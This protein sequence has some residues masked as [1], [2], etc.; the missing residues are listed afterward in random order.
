MARVRGLV[1]DAKG[2]LDESFVGH[3][4]PHIVAAHA[5]L[6]G[7][8][9]ERFRIRAGSKVVLADRVVLDF[10]T[11]SAMPPLDGLDFVPFIDAENRVELDEFP[12]RLLILGGSYIALEI[13]QA[14]R[15]W[16]AEVVVLQNGKQLMEREDEDVAEAL[17]Q[18]LAADGVEIRLDV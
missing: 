13:A 12:R 17:R 1:A 3:D 15:R 6:D 18:A 9:K 7:R 14:F 4:N 10:G 16:G 11:R 5:R 8:H 2:S